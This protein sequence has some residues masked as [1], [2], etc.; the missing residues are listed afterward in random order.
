MFAFLLN[1]YVK[2]LTPNVIEFGGGVLW[3]SLALINGINV[4][5]NETLGSPLSLPPCEDSEK[6]V[7]CAPGI[8][9]SPD[10]ESVVPLSQASQPPEVWEIL[11]CCW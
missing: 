10:P 8:E 11:I 7:M 9:P 1:S 4:L 2:I 5:M 6:T 3:R